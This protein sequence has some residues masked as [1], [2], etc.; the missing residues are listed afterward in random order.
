MFYLLG[1]SREVKP[2][3]PSP[4]S[5]ISVE[6]VHGGLK[7]RSVSESKNCCFFYDCCCLVAQSCPTLCDPVDC[8]LPGSSVHGI[9]QVRMLE[10]VAICFS[11]GSSWSRVR[12]ESFVSPTLPGRF[13]TTEPAG[14]SFFY[15]ATPQMVSNLNEWEDLMTGLICSLPLLFTW[16]CLWKSK[17]GNY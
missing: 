8:S 16:L 9:S 13:F 12:A 1:F 14:K 17:A 15:D 10:W 5:E 7:F 4:G 6:H 3:T 2:Q 11:R